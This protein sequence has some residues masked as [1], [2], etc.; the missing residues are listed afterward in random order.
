MSE[1]PKCQGRMEE[2]FIL[3]VGYGTRTP[4][5]WYAGT[6]VSSIWTGTKI[7]GVRN[8]PVVSL[9]CQRCGFLENYAKG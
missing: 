5:R 6:P 4:S 9:R 8:L 7:R 3:D 1:C 2:G